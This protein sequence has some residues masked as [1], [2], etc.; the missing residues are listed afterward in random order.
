MSAH[1]A[2]AEN[3]PETPSLDTSG[4]PF[5]FRQILKIASHIQYGTLEFELPDGRRLTIEGKEE[6]EAKGVILIHRYRF[7]RRAVFGGDIGFAFRLTFL[8][9]CDELERPVVAEFYQRVFGE[10]LPESSANLAVMA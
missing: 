6:K 7:A 5:F 4:L 1:Q 8:N 3:A 2:I 10:D 9:K